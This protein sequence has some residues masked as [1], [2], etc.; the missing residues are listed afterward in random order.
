MKS[1]FYCFVAILL[2][3][4][5]CS[6]GSSGG[7]SVTPTT[8]PVTP[9]TPPVGTVTTFTTSQVSTA[10]GMDIVISKTDPTVQLQT[11]S[12]NVQ[13]FVGDYE[14]LDASGMSGTTLMQGITKNNTQKY[15][16]FVRMSQNGQVIPIAPVARIR[17][18]LKPQ[19]SNTSFTGAQISNLQGWFQITEATNLTVN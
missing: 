2:L 7:G 1:N 17:Y 5:A 6:G 11:F 9:S 10:D 13:R 18:K 8:T 4:V 14:L 19:G 3:T 16:L 15:N 12:L